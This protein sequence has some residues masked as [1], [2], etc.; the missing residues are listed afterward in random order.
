MLPMLWAFDHQYFWD[1]R[2]DR[3][4]QRTSGSRERR[5]GDELRKGLL[6]ALEDVDDLSTS[7]HR[8]VV[9]NSERSVRFGGARDRDRK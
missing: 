2:R 1:E 7:L 4:M 5:F 6:S 8:R 9:A 3:S